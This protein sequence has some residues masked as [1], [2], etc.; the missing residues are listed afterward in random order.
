MNPGPAEEA[1]RIAG[2][3]AEALKAQ[4]LALAL[5]VLNVL[6]LAA[7]FW[8]AHANGVREDQILT[9]LIKSCMA[10]KN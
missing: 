3:V 8:L 9:D 1:A 6:W 7:V 5:I 2:G 10:L 4:P